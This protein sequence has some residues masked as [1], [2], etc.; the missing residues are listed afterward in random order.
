[1][2]IKIVFRLDN[3]ALRGLSPDRQ[4]AGCAPGGPVSTVGT[5]SSNCNLPSNVRLATMSR[6]TS[7]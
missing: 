2:P 1:M 6:A 4:E 7:G 3:P 5:Y